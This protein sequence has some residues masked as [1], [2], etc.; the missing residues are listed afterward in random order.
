MTVVPTSRRSP[1]AQLDA[2]PTHLLVAAS[3]VALTI[4]AAGISVAGVLAYSGLGIL[5]SATLAVATSCLASTLI[6]LATGRPAHLPSSVVTGLIVAL[7]AWP[8]TAPS[9]LLTVVWASVAAALVKGF[10]LWKG[11]A[12]LNPAAAGLVVAGILL[13]LLGIR[14]T[15]EAWWVA[16]EPLLWLLLL[17]GVL[18]LTRTRLE[19]PALV[20]IVVAVLGTVLAY[21]ISGQGL[22]EAARSAITQ[23]PVL[24]LTFFMFSEPVTL[25]ERRRGQIAVA[26]LVG[27]L[28]ALP[29]LAQTQGIHLGN[30]SW[31]FGP[32]AALL[33][34]NLVGF[35]LDRRRGCV[36]TLTGSERHGDLVE[37]RFHA[38][39]PLRH[40]AGQW[41]EVSL[42]HRADLRGQRRVFSVAS[43][44]GEDEVRIGVRAAEPLSSFKRELLALETGARVP[45]TRQGGDFTPA[46]GTSRLMI[47]AGVG[48]TPFLSHLGGS[49][50]PGD[51]SVLVLLLREGQPVPF[52]DAVSKADRVIVV[53]PS[54]PEVMR[55]EWEFRPGRLDSAALAELVPDVAERQVLVSGSPDQTRR[56][57]SLAN[58]AGATGVKVDAFSGY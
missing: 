33:V 5:A 16:S 24:F 51:D 57:R 44:P 19:V 22:V 37:L 42:P 43:A 8:S 9:D 45:I 46:A 23:G 15:T 3:L 12:I 35:I 25:P 2:V 40:R 39:P 56:L 1:R 10:L 28:V 4:A 48:V 6:G 29:A 52:P 7:V 55:G 31:A 47:A 49:D 32:A 34:G 36:L 41:V 26:A 27:V 21:T 18:V 38:D 53:A 58:Q 11:R 50:G 17:C 30:A 14:A 54:E 20:L 13:P